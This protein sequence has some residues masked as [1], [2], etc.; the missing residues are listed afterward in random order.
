MNNIQDYNANLIVVFIFLI[1]VSILSFM[2]G[3]DVERKRA[4][5]AGAAEWIIDPQSGVREFI[6]L[7]PQEISPEEN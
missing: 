2:A 1:F 3:G 6:W 4:L 5:E 7:V